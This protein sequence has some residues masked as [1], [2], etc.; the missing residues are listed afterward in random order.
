MLAAEGGSPAAIG[1]RSERLLAMNLAQ[2]RASEVARWYS[3]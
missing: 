1:S 3:K 2:L